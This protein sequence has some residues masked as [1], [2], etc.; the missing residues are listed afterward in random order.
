MTNCEEFFVDLLVQAEQP[1][2]HVGLNDVSEGRWSHVSDRAIIGNADDTTVSVD[3]HKTGR[4]HR[5]TQTV[6]HQ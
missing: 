3:E 4:L 6:C 2:R 1:E 5:R